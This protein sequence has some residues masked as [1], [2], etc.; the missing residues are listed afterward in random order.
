MV[1]NTHV[2]MISATQILAHDAATNATSWKQC[3]RT[4][5]D[6]KGLD[7]VLNP[8]CTCDACL[9]AWDPTGNKRA[10]DINCGVD[11]G[12]ELAKALLDR[13]WD[14]VL[15]IL[16][17]EESA[18]RATLDSLTSRRDRSLEKETMVKNHEC[19]AKLWRLE[20]KLGSLKFRCSD[21]A[22]EHLSP[23]KFEEAVAEFERLEPVINKAI[24]HCRAT[25][26]L[27]SEDIE[28]WS[29]QEIENAAGDWKLASDRLAEYK[30]ILAVYRDRCD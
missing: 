12:E 11:R 17:G 1:I 29:E 19:S 21:F 28:P 10:S 6:R 23:E 2:T 25:I 9:K 20:R 15:P 13:Y 4:A 27:L 3:Y 16:M 7:D 22:K 30:E 14:V 26:R 5:A 18:R 24:R 8:Y